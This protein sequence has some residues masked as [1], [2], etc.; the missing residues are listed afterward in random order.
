MTSFNPD[1][2][3]FVKN[4]GNDYCKKVWLGLYDGDNRAFDGHRDEQ[5]MKDFLILVRITLSFTIVCWYPVERI[6][7]YNKRLY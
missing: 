3:D 4:R 6:L 5:Q 2:I 1:E 7:F